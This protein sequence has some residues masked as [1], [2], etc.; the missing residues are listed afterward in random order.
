MQLVARGSQDKYISVEPEITFFKAHHRRHTN[1]ATESIEQT[2]NGTA[3][4]GGRVSATI[5]RNGDLVHTMWLE[6]TSDM[7]SQ[8]ATGL[9]LDGSNEINLSTQGLGAGTYILRLDSDATQ[10]FEFTL[11][12]VEPSVVIDGN[13]AWE[14]NVGTFDTNLS[15][16][17][18]GAF[19]LYVAD[20]YNLIKQISVEIGG[21][22]VDRQTGAF[23]K[24]A[25]DLSTPTGKRANLDACLGA[26]AA[27]KYLIPL[28]FWFCKDAGQALPLIALQYHEV[29]VV[30]E[31]GSLAVQDAKLW[32]DYIY[33]DTEERKRFA[34]SKHEYLIEQI[35]TTGEET[36]SGSKK[37]RLNF[38]HPVKEI[39]WTAPSMTSA[40]L[41]LNGHDRFTERDARYFK[42]LQQYQHHTAQSSDAFVYSF[43]LEPEKLQP[44]GTCNFSRIDNATLNLE[45]ASTATVY[46][47]NYNVL[48]IS[49]GMGGLAYSN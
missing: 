29:K 15:G 23:M 39:I 13:A 1:F 17:V 28:S 22:R 2:F 44:S 10:Y 35:Q 38:N 36:L 3:S 18:T 26:D 9:S 6:V 7:E 8:L 41:Q 16:V 21:T 46:A 31:F 32:V 20:A 5:S 11:T 48:R 43:A 27:N 37:V 49:N 40:K 19:S 42:N 47:C 14:S 30:V 25:H 4:A 33:L 12:Q 45:G 34:R 24:I